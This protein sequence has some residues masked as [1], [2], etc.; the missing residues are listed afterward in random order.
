MTIPPRFLDEI[1]SRLTLSDMIGKRVKVVRAGRE[2]KACC[3]FHKEKSPSFT[4]N[5]DKQFYHCFGCGAHGDVIHFFMKHDNLSFMDAVEMLS[6]EAGLKM[7]A[8]DPM[9]AA[10]A[11]KTRDLNA[12]MEEATSYFIVALEKPGAGEEALR[13]ILERGMSREMIAA[14][15]V[16][17][18][19]ADGQPMRKHLLGQG[20]TDKQMIEVGLVKPSSKP[21]GEPYGFFRDRIMFPVR[22]RRGNVVAF[23]G[24]VMPEHLRP[25]RSDGFVPAKY[26]N[27]S[28]TPLFDK[29]R[30]L[31]GEGLARQAA[32]EGHSVIVTE[33]YMDVIACHQAG[34]KGAVAP[35]GTALTEEQIL[36]LWSMIPDREKNPILCF[37]GDKAGRSAASR[38]CDRVLPLLKPDQSVRIAFIPE[39]ED[40]DSL[41]R[42]GGAQAL[43]KILQASLSLFDFLW[44]TH[45]VGRNF[46]TPESRAGLKKALLDQ[47]AHITDRDIQKHYQELV[48]TRISESFFSRYKGA[49]P[50][51]AASRNPAGKSAMKLKRPSQA[52]SDMKERI[53]LAAVVNHPHIYHEIEEAFGQFIPQSQRLDHF[54][55]AVIN[56]IEIDSDIDSENLRSSLALAG[57]EQECDDILSESVYLHAAFCRPKSGPDLVEAQWMEIW[58][59]LQSKGMEEEI[60][61]GWKKAFENSNEDEE[62][63]MRA[64][65][66]AGTIQEV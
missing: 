30:M 37:D 33:G 15:R 38:A 17:Y 39:G 11:E 45:T 22:D 65:V 14:F 28:D 43:Q 36:S 21:G 12:L 4:I 57:F 60:K 29:G 8:L 46:E 58:K 54:R 32:R 24:R 18:A 44:M 49:G 40:P 64:M 10:K 9:A 55:Q 51:A 53:L 20:Y 35:M 7:P 61:R 62:E 52:V 19:P 23:G 66:R 47:I 26:M 48:Y 5:D 63:K 59:S 41:I 3:P 25:P 31:Y 1:R 6:A 27:S 16:G 13:Y 50:G 2:S 34:F 42:T 56:Q